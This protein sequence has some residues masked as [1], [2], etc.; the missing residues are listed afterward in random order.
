L[1]YFLFCLFVLLILSEKNNNSEVEKLK[2]TLF[3]VELMLTLENEKS[4]VLA[5]ELEEQKERNAMMMQMGGGGGGVANDQTVVVEKYK[6][7][8]SLL[9][10]E[11][12]TSDDQIAKYDCLFCSILSFFLI[13]NHILT[14]TLQIT[15]STREVPIPAFWLRLASSQQR[16]SQG[17]E[18]W[19]IRGQ[20]R[21][22][23]GA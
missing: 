20:R 6:R 11:K 2:E 9:Q 4:A 15:S 13:R 7:A 8:V 23:R 18:W 14:L 21:R 5:R 16:R 22:G 17:A 3:N 1:F 12:K 19:R 10:H